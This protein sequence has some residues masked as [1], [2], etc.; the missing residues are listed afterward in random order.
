[1]DAATEALASI[2]S[3]LV[4]A[5]LLCHPQP[6]TQTSLMVDTSDTAIS[7]VFEERIGTNWKPL[8]FLSKSLN[9]TFGR[10]LLAA[11]LQD[12]REF[13]IITE[14]RLLTHTFRSRSS[15]YSLTETISPSWMSSLPVSNT[16]SPFRTALWTP[17]SAI[18]DL[19][20]HVLAQA[21]HEDDHLRTFRKPY[22]A[23]RLEGTILPGYRS[24]RPLHHPNHSCL[25]ILL[26]RF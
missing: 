20:L 4:S 16:C 25:H 22:T 10:E 8:A 21:Q 11:Y 7:A 26:C 18:S 23:P 17:S 3:L 6:G 24:P 12:S 1:M 5:A 19:P 9:R 15:H 13:F 14:H 2:K